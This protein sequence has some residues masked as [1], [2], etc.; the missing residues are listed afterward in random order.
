M[1]QC[2]ERDLAHH[3]VIEFIRWEEFVLLLSMMRNTK[4]QPGKRKGN[5]K[6]VGRDLHEDTSDRF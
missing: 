4:L 1:A 6:Y 2:N 3:H 5:V